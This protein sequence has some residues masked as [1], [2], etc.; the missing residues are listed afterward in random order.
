MLSCALTASNSAAIA[1]WHPR[2]I[3]YL[4]PLLTPERQLPEALLA[5]AVLEPDAESAG[6]MSVFVAVEALLKGIE[7]PFPDG[8]S[9][10]DADGMRRTKLRVS[11]WAGSAYLPL[12]RPP[13][14]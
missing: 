11:W 12:P 13:L 10:V 9:F 1:C 6:A 5:A 7:L 4:R 3:E 2:A 8:L 14:P